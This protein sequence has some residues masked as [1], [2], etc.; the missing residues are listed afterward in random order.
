MKEEKTLAGY[1]VTSQTQ[2][3]EARSL[4]PGTSTQ[5]MVLTGFT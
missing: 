1:A 5:A 3:R 2:V 4:P